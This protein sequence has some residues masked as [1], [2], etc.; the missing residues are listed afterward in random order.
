MALLPGHKGNDWGIALLDISTGEFFVSTIGHDAY[1]QNLLPRSHATA[2]P[3]AS[4]PQ[5]LARTCGSPP[6]TVSWSPVSVT[7]HSPG[8]RAER[9]LLAPF[10]RDL[11]CRISACDDM[12]AG[13]GAAG[14]AL[15]Y[16]QETQQSSSRTCQQPFHRTS[17]QCMMLDAVTLR[18]LEVQES[19]RGGTKGATLFSVARPDKDPDG[20]PAPAPASHPPAHGY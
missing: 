8:T 12:P 16:A 10:P 3:N 2:R 14:A 7:R 11:P 13:I 18:N 1:L 5:Q 19:I 4:F 6:G 17:S 9:T 15:A 20:Q